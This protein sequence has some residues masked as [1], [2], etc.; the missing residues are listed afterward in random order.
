[1][2]SVVILNPKKRD[3]YTKRGSEE[4]L[5]EWHKVN[6]RKK[7]KN[8]PPR[9]KRVLW[10]KPRI[11]QEGFWYFFGFIDASGRIDDNYGSQRP[12]TDYY[13]CYTEDIENPVGSN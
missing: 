5:M 9:N 13:W 1:M 6:M 4:N 7:D 2:E 8:L 11:D 12:K 3:L 10:A